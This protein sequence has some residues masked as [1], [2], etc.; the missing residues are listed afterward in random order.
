MRQIFQIL[1]NYQSRESELVPFKDLEVAPIVVETG[2][3][4]FD[5]SLLVEDRA[6]GLALWFEYSKDLFVAETIERL[7]SHYTALLEAIVEQPNAQ[8]IDLPILS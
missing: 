2:T 3:A 6:D 7:A 8:L 1:F 5:L 4:K